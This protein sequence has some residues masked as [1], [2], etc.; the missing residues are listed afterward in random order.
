MTWI[1]WLTIVPSVLIV[2]VLGV[3]MAFGRTPS[4]L[5][6]RRDTRIATALVG[7]V[8]LASCLSLAAALV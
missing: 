2:L 5:P 4:P 3:R 7:F 8:L 6:T 1:A